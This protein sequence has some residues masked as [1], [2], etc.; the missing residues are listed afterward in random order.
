MLDWIC[1]FNSG[2]F[3]ITNLQK[4]DFCVFMALVSLLR[5]PVRRRIC[6]CVHDGEEHR[7]STR[8]PNTHD[9]GRSPSRP[10]GREMRV[11]LCGNAADVVRESNG[12]VNILSL[13]SG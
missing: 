12:R 5:D 4:S 1:Q 9:H 11:R 13:P 6:G 3:E 7:L 8:P 10:A 2:T